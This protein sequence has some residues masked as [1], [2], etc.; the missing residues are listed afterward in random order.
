[1]CIIARVPRNSKL[2]KAQ[3]NAMWDNNPHGG[4]IA[5]IDGEEVKVFKSLKKSEF[6]NA[7]F[8]ISKEF[9]SRDMLV[10]TRIR[11]HGDICIDNVHPFQV[12]ENTFMAHNGTIDEATPPEKFSEKS[13]TNWFVEHFMS[14]VDVTALDDPHFIDMLGNFIGGGPMELYQ[15]YG[16][17]LV[18]LTADK[19]TKN[20][21][22]V[23]NSHLGQSPGKGIWF[24]NGSY[25]DKKS[26][27]WNNKKKSGN[28]KS[29]QTTMHQPVI[30]DPVD[31][32]WYT[33][34]DDGCLVSFDSSYD[35]VTESEI[36][37]METYWKP[38]YTEFT[39]VGLTTIDEI[40][41]A[42]GITC[43]D[44]DGFICLD[45]AEKVSLAQYKCTKGCKALEQRELWLKDNAPSVLH[46][47]TSKTKS[48]SK[49]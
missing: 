25:E 7:Y 45:C 19:R 42:V 34:D 28:K 17:K 31:D 8:N 23:I 29:S 24:S 2:T 30:F 22:Y 13:D 44:T 27:S 20:D 47:K 21:S 10:H 12:N 36:N 16:N 46:T 15:W 32:D 5:Y 48:Q 26:K 37:Y 9:G 43:V 14:H 18:F 35:F 41:D 6:I 33:A 49:K 3:L 38:E 40:Q 1:L 11:T 39:E 4:G